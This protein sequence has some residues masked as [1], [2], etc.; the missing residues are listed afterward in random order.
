M[1]KFTLR[2][3]GYLSERLFAIAKARGI[4]LQ[5]L[6]TEHLEKQFAKK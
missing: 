2:M 5:Q 3:P 1:K 6:I 4:S